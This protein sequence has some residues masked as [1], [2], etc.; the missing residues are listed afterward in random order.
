M[1][2]TQII[3]GLL[4]RLVLKRLYC[5]VEYANNCIVVVSTRIRL[6]D[7]NVVVNIKLIVLL[8]GE[9][10]NNNCINVVNTLTVVFRG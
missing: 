3:V 4:L 5:C 7:C 10:S 2:N 9:Y 6:N 8:C 1:V